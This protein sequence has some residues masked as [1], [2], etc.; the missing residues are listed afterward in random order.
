M[1][2]VQEL[3]EGNRCLKKMYAET[4]LKAE[5]VKETMAKKW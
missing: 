3:E 1:K 2:R 5:I 4:K